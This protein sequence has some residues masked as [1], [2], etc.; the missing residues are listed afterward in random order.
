VVFFGAS[1][2]FGKLV[3]FLRVC[4]GVYVNRV[5]LVRVGELSVKRG[6][7]RKEM[8]RLLLSAMKEAADECGGA[9]IAW[10]PGRF[11]AW[12]DVE[13]LKRV[14]SRVFGVKSVSPTYLVRF[15]NLDE[16]ADAAARLWGDVVQ[17]RRFAVRVHRWGIHNFTSL[18]AAA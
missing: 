18:D 11:Y 9:K 12:G 14:L 6:W 15:S 16:V 5:V 1:L 4:M 3:G 7:T 17:G 8:E 13:C 2:A 10:E